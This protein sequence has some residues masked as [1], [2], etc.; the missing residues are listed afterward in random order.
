MY[1]TRKSLY[2]LL[3]FLDGASITA[4]DAHDLRKS[5]EKVLARMS[6]AP[7]RTTKTALGDR[8]MRAVY[9]RQKAN[10]SVEISAGDS[11]TIVG[12]VT[13]YGFVAYSTVMGAERCT[14]QSAATTTAA[15]AAQRRN[16][17]KIVL[18][19]CCLMEYQG[20]FSTVP[21]LSS[22]DSLIRE[23]RDFVLDNPKT[24]TYR[25]F[26]LLKRHLIKKYLSAE[27]RA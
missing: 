1:F 3:A 17:K 24:E 10:T 15:A 25:L 7:S 2:A 23:A 5:A 14:D 20:I 9:S 13:P 18:A 27:T 6:T 16:F 8:S 12:A 11:R 26:T 22:F 4:S 19:A 21:G